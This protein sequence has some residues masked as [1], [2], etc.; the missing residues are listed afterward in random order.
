MDMKTC[1]SPVRSERTAMRYVSKK[2]QKIDTDFVPSVLYL[3]LSTP[4]SPVS[5]SIVGV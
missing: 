2:T 3:G 4:T 1:E 5:F